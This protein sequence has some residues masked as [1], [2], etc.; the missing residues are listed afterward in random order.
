M[1]NLKLEVERVSINNKQGE[2]Y[3]DFAI[4]REGDEAWIEIRGNE[5]SP[6]FPL[7]LENHEDIDQF[8]LMLKSLIN[9]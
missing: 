9:K 7:V 1:S 8:C 3:C 6:E 4:E 2:G 5:K